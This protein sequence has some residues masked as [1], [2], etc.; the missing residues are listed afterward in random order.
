MQL[1]QLRIF[2]E[3]ARLSS[4]SKAAQALFITQPTVSA[5]IRSLED[6][7]GAKLFVRSTKGLSLTCEGRVFFTYAAQIVNFCERAQDELRTMRG[8]GETSLTVAASTVPAQYLLPEILPRVRERFGNVKLRVNEGDSAEALEMVETGA[9]AL[10]VVGTRAERAGLR[11][12]PVIEEEL[13]AA[14][15]DTEYFRA[16]EGRL[17]PDVVQNFPFIMREEGSGTRERTEQLLESIGVR[18]EGLREAAVL[19]GTETVLRAVMNGLGISIVSRLAAQ[20]FAPAGELVLFRFDAP[21][22]KR[23]FY[24]VYREDMP[25]GAAAAFIIDELSALGAAAHGDGE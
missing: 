11:F 24:A 25:L 15:P 10:G 9:A 19:S 7:L 21:Y 12:V 20:R 14:A 1:R 8:G 18:T 16:M 13:V 2:I 5:H 3:V 4:F 23:Q 6:E 22:A 17:A